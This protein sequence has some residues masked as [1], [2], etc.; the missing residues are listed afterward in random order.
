MKYFVFIICFHK[1]KC[2]VHL[3]MVPLDKTET[4]IS[5]ANTSFAFKKRFSH[6]GATGPTQSAP[7]L[8][9]DIGK[10]CNINTD[11]GFSKCPYFL[12]QVVISYLKS[13]VNLV[14]ACVCLDFF[15]SVLS[16]RPVCPVRPQ[17]DLGKKCVCLNYIC[18]SCLS[19]L[20]CPSPRRLYVCLCLNYICPSCLSPRRLNILVCEFLYLCKSYSFVL[21]LCPQTWIVDSSAS[22]IRCLRFV[23]FV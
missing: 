9:L 3:D 4:T 10:W 18:P 13:Q 11:R 7:I 8:L 16:V 12:L 1:F 14:G 22:N 23:Y 15:M 17:E 2:P 21:P 5:P 6:P 20:S 19:C